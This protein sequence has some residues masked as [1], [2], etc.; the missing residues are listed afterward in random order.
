MLLNCVTTAKR[1]IEESQTWSILKPCIF[2][3]FP[4][5][6]Q[7]DCINQWYPESLGWCVSIMHNG[8]DRWSPRIPKSEIPQPVRCQERLRLS[9][10]ADCAGKPNQWQVGSKSLSGES[11]WQC[12]TSPQ[13]CFSRWILSK[14]QLEVVELSIIVIIHLILFKICVSPKRVLRVCRRDASLDV[15][16]AAGCFPWQNQPQS[17]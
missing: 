17:C 8:S 6:S 5:Q 13:R 4:C 7:Q 14:W 15:L 10:T 1:W 11:K 2:M 3:Y 16:I 9:A 12:T